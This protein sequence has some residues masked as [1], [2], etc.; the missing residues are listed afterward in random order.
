MTTPNIFTGILTVFIGLVGFYITNVVESLR[1]GYTAVHYFEPQRE[2]ET[3]V[4]HLVN[5]SRSKR[6]DAARFLIKCSDQAAECFKIVPGSNPASFVSEVTT[7]PNF[8]RQIDSGRSGPAAIQ[9]CLG[10][11]ASSRTSIRVAPK[12]GKSVP[13][14]ALYDPWSKDCAPTDAEATN[15]L[16]LGRRDPH[17]FFVQHYFT[18]ITAALVVSSAIL[19]IT[20]IGIAAHRFWKVSRGLR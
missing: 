15:L 8:G 19:A 7:P 17:A 5:V 18:L 10:A 9:V 3:V 20:G 12:G 13:L 2:T 14:I 1:S 11:I 16:L 6:I 4:F